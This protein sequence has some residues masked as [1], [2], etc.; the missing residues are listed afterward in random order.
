[1]SDKVDKIVY[2]ARDLVE[3]MSP[4]DRLL[5]GTDAPMTVKYPQFAALVRAVEEA[6]LAPDER[7]FALRERDKVAPR[8]LR[9]YSIFC[10]EAGSPSAHSDAAR[11]DADE[12]EEWQRVNRLLAKVPD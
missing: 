12:F 6:A 2:A 7:V 11:R 9:A 8:T 1:M 10:Q 5:C 3:S 4:E